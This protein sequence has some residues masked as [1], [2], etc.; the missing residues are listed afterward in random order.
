M[1]LVV[2]AL[3]A[4]LYIEM[5]Y[6]CT[7]SSQYRSNRNVMWCLNCIVKQYIEQQKHV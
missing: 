6:N 1:V 2:D 7:V 3:G 5:L 4:L